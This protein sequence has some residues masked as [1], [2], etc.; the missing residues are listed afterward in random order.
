MKKPRCPFCD[1]VQVHPVDVDQDKGKIQ[2]K[3]KNKKCGELFWIKGNIGKPKPTTKKKT[4]KKTTKKKTVKKPAKKTTKKKTAKKPGKKAAKSKGKKPAKKQL[5]RANQ[6]V[7]ADELPEGFDKTDPLANTQHENFCRI[8]T[9]QGPSRNQAEAYISAGF[10]PKDKV[11]AGVNASQLLKKH[12]EV[13]ARLQYM[14][15]AAA[16]DAILSRTDAM[17][18]LSQQAKGDVSDYMEMD[19]KGHVCVRFDQLMLNTKAIKKVKTKTVFD[20][21]GNQ[22]Q[23]IVLQDL[24]LHSSKGAIDSLSKMQGWNEPD[25]LDVHHTGLED[26]FEAAEGEG[27]KL[28]G[29]EK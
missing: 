24:E 10:N 16:D 17:M 6:P 14:Q 26:V 12:P 28:P 11:V 18:I 15:Q 20:D 8:L 29:G 23:V 13:R 19:E 25:K 4:A 27:L 22:A 5:K 2:M 1:S 7:S 3:C 9:A 21:E